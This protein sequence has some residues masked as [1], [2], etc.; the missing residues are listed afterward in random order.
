MIASTDSKPTLVV[1][2]AG[3]GSRYGGLKQIDPV[4]PH[5]QTIIDYSIHDARRGGFGTVCFVIRRDIERPFREL[6]GGRFESQIPVEYVFQE[7][8]RLPTGFS[9]PESRSKPWGT[10]HAV[11]AAAGAV[12]QPFGVI[13]AD[14]FYGQM[15]FK[16]LAQHLQAA[17]SDYAMVG[18]ILRNTLSDF[19]AVARGVC[20]TTSDD[21][22]EQVTELT[23]IE[24]AGEG[25]KNTNANG[26]V[27]PLSGSEIASMN[28]WGFTPA[29]FEQ[30]E[31]EMSAFLRL[32]L[33]DPKAEF[34]L[35]TAVNNLIAAGVARV[36][37]LRTEDC[38]AGVTFRQDRPRVIQSIQALIRAGQYPEKL[39]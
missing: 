35:T 39:W 15:S 4:G 33:Q 28:M 38:W 8:T 21:F 36:K 9:A 16:L 1:L 3:I 14:D 25:A 24:K 10:G 34:Y 19:G 7:L 17:S 37:V 18:F 23:Q 30:L 11:L 26:Q 13:N 32:H 12:R 27:Q 2:A 5:A 20:A 22:L 6:V 31:R 29:I